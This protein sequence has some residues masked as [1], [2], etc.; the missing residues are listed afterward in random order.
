M[1][2]DLRTFYCYRVRNG[3]LE[4][5]NVTT[6]PN[7]KYIITMDKYNIN[8]KESI[9]NGKRSLNGKSVF[10]EVFVKYL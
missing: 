3:I 6:R 5:E 7:I 4:Y 8:V 2:N 9:R 1:K 10:F